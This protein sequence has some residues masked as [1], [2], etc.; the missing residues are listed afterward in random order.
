V[1]ARIA[2]IERVRQ[3]PGGIVDPFCVLKLTPEMEE[4]PIRPSGCLA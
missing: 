1:T 4:V 3:I 2:S